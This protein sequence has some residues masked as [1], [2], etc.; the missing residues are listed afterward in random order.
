MVTHP[1]KPGGYDLKCKKEEAVTALYAICSFPDNRRRDV[2]AALLFAA[3]AIGFAWWRQ[4]KPQKQFFD[5]PAEEDPE[6]HLG[7]LKRFS[8]ARITSCNRWF[9]SGSEET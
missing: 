4:R 2:G 6:V 3:S 8:F 1:P 5:V 7:Q 9:I